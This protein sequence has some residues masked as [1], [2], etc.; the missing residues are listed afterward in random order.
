MG[1]R[2]LSTCKAKTIH[3]V[4]V[5]LI[6]SSCIKEEHFNVLSDSCAKQLEKNVTFQEVKKLYQ[7]EALEIPHDWILEGYVIS[8]DKEG[9]FFNSLHFQDHPVNPTQGF[10]ID[11]DI[12]NNHLFYEV[13]DKIYIK[14]KG[15]YIGKSKGVLKLGGAY[16]LFGNLTIGRL[17]A[18]SVADHIW[19]DCDQETQIRPNPL[20][21]DMVTDQLVNTLIKIEHVEFA[22][23][24][25]GL[26]FAPKEEMSKRTLVNCTGDRL[27]MLNSGY[28]SFYEAIV[29]NK[30]GSVKGVLFKENNEFQ[31]I[32]RDT[33]DISFDQ[34]RCEEII[35]EFTSNE[36]FIS[37]IADPE[38]NS[39]ARFVELY[40]AGID[41]IPLKGW[42]LRRY[43]NDNITISS[44]IDLSSYVIRANQ[45]LVIASNILE[46]ESTYGFP[47]DVE[48]GSNSPA[49]SNGDDNLELVDPF[50]T[51][52]DVFGVVG[53][54]G[55]GT[56]HEFEDGGAFRNIVV[57]NGNPVYT[58][59]EWT[60]FNDTGAS[61][62]NNEPKNA[63][64][65]FT[66]G[67]RE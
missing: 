35:T 13:G 58:F 18:L 2:V 65:D 54:D 22:D 37:E 60:L 19:V 24:E 55:S 12:R 7:G 43:T 42:S 59:S 20:G 1:K 64:E 5:L 46:F 11:L 38:N 29:P 34:E 8:S 15:L 67:V 9:N 14:L 63:P 23:E 36:I 28:S 26:P 25:L 17:P 41:S 31:L 49:D 53:E 3:C 45:T 48:G 44:A 61:G 32:I 52:I 39:G 27:V 4:I 33:L 6:V 50:G 51:V 66:P 40:N 30:N 21:I 57:V 62:T 10:Q 56:N 16:E 47:P